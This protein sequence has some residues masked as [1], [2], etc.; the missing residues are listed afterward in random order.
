MYKKMYRIAISAAIITAIAVLFGCCGASG[1]RRI[2]E[3]RLLLDT[4]CTITVYGDVD[5]QLLN[6]AF[7]LIEEYEALL[8]ITVPDSDVWRINSAEGE[9]V[10]VSRKTIEV[11][12]AAMEFGGLTDGVFDIT[13]GRLSRLWEFGGEPSV[14]PVAGLEELL[15]TVDY[16]Q[17]QITEDT[18]QLTN[19]DA[20]IDL[21]A[22]AKGYIGNSIAAFLTDKGVSGALIDLGGDIVAIGSRPGGTP[23]RIAV[24][25]PY[26]EAEDWIGVIEVADAAVISSGIYERSF[27]YNGVLYH[28][29]LD[30]KTGFPAKSDIISATVVTKDAVTGEAL[31]TA[32]VLMGSE[33]SKN[34]FDKTPGF[35]GAVLITDIGDMIIVGDI[36][37]SRTP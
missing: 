6:D 21:G 3:T 14:P 13:I 31:S 37:F 11:V 34:L 26:G 24:R 7:E 16:T 33:E 9:A 32:A 36:A 35:I 19:P 23:W 4:Y 27:E 29:I 10:N 17:I 2:S 20:W 1:G 28:H 5:K 30:P 8:S 12:R 15:K 22:I 18:I 25:E